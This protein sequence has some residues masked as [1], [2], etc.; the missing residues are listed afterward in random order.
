NKKVIRKSFSRKYFPKPR[1]KP[2]IPL[3]LAPLGHFQ[4]SEIL[5]DGMQF[6]FVSVRSFFYLCK[7][8][9]APEARMSADRS[10]AVC[11]SDG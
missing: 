9:E 1:K 4:G 7:V 2:R 10:G 6:S 11:F 3:S 5:S 8:K